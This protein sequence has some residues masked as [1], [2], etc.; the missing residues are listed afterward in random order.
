MKN[1]KHYTVD[2][3]NKI[4]IADIIHL[5]EE[6]IKEVQRH[7]L[8]GYMVTAKEKKKSSVQRLNDEYICDFLKDDA[9]G[10]KSYIAKKAENGKKGFIAA[11]NWFATTYP[12]KIE[13][14][15]ISSEQRAAIPAKYEAYKKAFEKSAKKKKGE[16]A[17]TEEQY[18]R[19]YYWTK[20]FT[21]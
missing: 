12:K 9:E 11:R 17:Y 7:Q 18:M 2:N 1:Y 14:L 8:F 4:I 10:L 5:T 6:E 19:Y 20:I 13:E 3:E 16:T 15:D 21:R